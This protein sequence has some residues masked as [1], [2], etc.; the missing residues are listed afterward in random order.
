MAHVKAVKH[1]WYWN[2][3]LRYHPIEVNQD[4][5]SGCGICVAVCSYDATKLIESNKGL[6]AVIDDLK[7]K[8]CGVC[9]AACPAEAMVIKDGFMETIANTLTVL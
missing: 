3:S 2:F 1:V 9:V 8:R 4:I 7:C 6:V 5:C